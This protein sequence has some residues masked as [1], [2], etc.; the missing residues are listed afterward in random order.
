MFSSS[1]GQQLLVDYHYLQQWLTS[2]DR[3]LK[4]GVRQLLSNLP[5]LADLEKGL[6]HICGVSLGEMSSAPQSVVKLDISL[7]CK[8]FSVF[9]EIAWNSEE[10][11]VKQ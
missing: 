7:P 4:E 11:W 1:T 3:K 10:D 9:S 2:S 6:L 8:Y 5:I